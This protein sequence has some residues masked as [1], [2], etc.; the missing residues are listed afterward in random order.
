MANA[1][2]PHDLNRF[3]TAQQGSGGMAGY[4][5]ALA[6]VRAGAKVTHWMWYVFP[7]FAGLGFS[8]MSQRYAIKSRAEAEAYL[9]HPVLGPRLV[10][11]AGAALGVEG[12]S[13]FDIFGDPDDAKLKSCATLFAH[14][15]PDGSV[16]HQLLER[17]FGGKRDEKT[18]RLLG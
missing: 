18:L 8:A 13:A 9:A 11:C 2:D 7:Q 10:E 1:S 6:E 15:S 12:K 5:T 3:V 14:V 16:F 17:F 4:A